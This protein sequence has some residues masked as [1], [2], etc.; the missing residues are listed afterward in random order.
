MVPE[1][2]LEPPV[3]SIHAFIERELARLDDVQVQAPS[4][5][6]MEK[7]NGIFRAA[8]HADARRIAVANGR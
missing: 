6:A 8:I 5:A 2:G 3:E 4:M 1:M 7:L